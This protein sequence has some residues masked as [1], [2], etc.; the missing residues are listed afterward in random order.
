MAIGLPGVDSS[1]VVTSQIDG[2]TL[3][4]L[5]V[6]QFGQAP[7][8]WGR[9]FKSPTNPGPAE[10]LHRIESQALRDQNIRVLPIAQQ[11]NHVGGTQDDGAADAQANA[12]DLIQS[13]GADYLQSLGGQVVMF[14]DVEG[15]PESLLS[16]DYYTG[17]SQT[18]VAHSQDYSQGAVSIQPCVYGVQS[19]DTTWTNLSSAVA[20]GA[21]CF[22]VWIA[23]WRYRG[24]AALPDFDLGLVQP[25][26]AIPCP[27]LLWQYSD[28]CNGP[29][30]F[31]CDEINPNID[32]ADFLNRCVLPPGN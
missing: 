29:S 10:Y 6:A 14:L 18:L 7:S 25:R 32:V 20:A 11:T 30:G 21:P 13:F 28:D 24:C 4:D 9:Y 31:D 19:D 2:Q 23:R 16:S 1:V 15:T 12:E 22:G 17:W 8:V 3:I 26:V 27:I 5:A